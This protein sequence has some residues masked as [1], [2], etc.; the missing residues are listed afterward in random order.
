MFIL[1]L[2]LAV[3]SFSVKLSSSG[4]ASKARVIVH[5]SPL[6][7]TL[8]KKTKTRISPVCRKRDSK[9]LYYC[10]LDD[11]SGER[12]KEPTNKRVNKGKNESTKGRTRERRNKRGHEGTNQR[13]N[14][15]TN[16]RGQK[17]MNESTRPRRNERGQKMSKRGHEG[18][19]EHT[20]KR[21]RTKN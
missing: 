9:S 3:F 14:E 19:N 2:P 20:K 11:K 13:T 12:T 16:E 21:R 8:L 5:C 1:H 6:C 15:R 7:T 4:L 10:A 18:T 17:G